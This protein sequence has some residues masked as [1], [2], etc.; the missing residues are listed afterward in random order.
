[1]LLSC[2]VSVLLAVRAAD[3]GAVWRE[4]LPA[5]WL[6]G[7][8]AAPKAHGAEAAIWLSTGV[9][10]SLSIPFFTLTVAVVSRRTLWEALDGMRLA[11][12]ITSAVLATGYLAYVLYAV[13]AAARDTRA[14]DRNMAREARAQ[15][16]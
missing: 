5:L 9:L 14:W 4:L 6:L 10:L 11:C 3:L 15:P 13:P 7:G 12:K 16:L 1:M 2:A 8:D